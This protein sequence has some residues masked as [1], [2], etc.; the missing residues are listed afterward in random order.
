MKPIAEWSRNI[1]GMMELDETLLADC[2]F[3]SEINGQ[4]QLFLCGFL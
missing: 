1:I 4:Q 3:S 2:M